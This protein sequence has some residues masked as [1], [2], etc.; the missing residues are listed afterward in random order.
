M[1]KYSKQL[2]RYFYNLNHAE[3]IYHRCNVYSVQVGSVQQGDLIELSCEIQHQNF[4]KVCFQCF[5]GTA[6]IAAC[7]FV[8]CWMEGKAINACHQLNSSLITSTLKLSKFE[9]HVA[10]RLMGAVEQLLQK[11]HQNA[12]Q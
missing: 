2:L 6:T 4:H 8:C 9:S 5:G 12:R 1:S 3:K 10:V 7:E 11:V